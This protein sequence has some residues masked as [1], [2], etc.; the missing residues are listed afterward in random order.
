M[1]DILVIRSP[2]LNPARLPLPKEKNIEI[3]VVDSKN[4]ER[5]EVNSTKKNHSKK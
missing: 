3:I 4:S 1:A 2:N 5:V